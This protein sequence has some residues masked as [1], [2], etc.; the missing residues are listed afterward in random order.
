LMDSKHSGRTGYVYDSL[1]CYGCH[2]TGKH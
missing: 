2:P 1:A